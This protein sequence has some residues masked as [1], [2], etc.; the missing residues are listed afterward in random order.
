MLGHGKVPGFYVLNSCS[1]MLPSGTGW[2]PAGKW[3]GITAR[4]SR[5]LVFEFIFNDW[6]NV[7]PIEGFSK[8]FL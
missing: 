5:R 4:F 2:T 8:S 3:E 1:L 7:N 6:Q